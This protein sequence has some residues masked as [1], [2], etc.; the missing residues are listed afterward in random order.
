MAVM[1]E[2]KCPCCGGALSFDSSI[3]KVKCPYCDTEFEMDTLIQYDEQLCGDSDTNNMNWGDDAG[4][5]WQDGDTD[6]LRTYVCKSCG[7]EIIGDENMAATLCPYCNNPVVLMGQFKGDLKPDYV[8]PFKLDKNAAKENLA[9]HLRGKILLPKSFK[10]KN[11]IDEIKG[12]YVPFWLFNADADARI[13]YRATKVVTW[14]DSDYNYTKTSFYSVIRAGSVGFQNIPVD[15]SSKMPDDLME[16]IEPFNFADAVDFQTAYLAGYL[17]DKYDVT[18]EQS[19]DRANQRIRKSTEDTFATT[20][21]G[22]SS[23]T[24]ENT[25][26]SLSNNKSK[27]ALFPVWLLNTTYEGKKY[28][29]AMNGQ[30]GKLVGDLPMDKRAYWKWWAIIAAA[31]SV[32]AYLLIMLFNYFF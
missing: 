13:R 3:Q 4:S 28:T 26:I 10:D 27:Y 11:H 15:G 25:S 19:I 8:I 1:Q 24:P 16:S 32:V 17:A 7:G 18:A 23:V 2:Y 29:F 5:Q 12:L 6:G 14:S 22:Y 30:T 20:V 9:R 31:G 21:N